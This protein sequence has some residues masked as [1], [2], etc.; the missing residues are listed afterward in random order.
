MNLR[1]IHYLV[2][3]ADLKSFSQAA[4]QCHISQPTLSAQVKKLEDLLGVQI[5]ERNNKR[6]MLT[7]TGERIVECARRI[8][9]EEDSIHAIANEA[10]DPFSGT[11][12]LG[13]FPTLASY[14]FPTVVSAIRADL[15]SLKLMLIEEKTAT[16]LDQIRAGTLDAAFIALP[17]QDPRLVET[18]LFDDEFF[19]AVPATH[20]LARATKVDQSILKQ[21]ELLLLDEG[22][23]LRDQA[24][25][26]CQL[27]G[28][29]E[30]T[31][32]RATSLETLRQ[33]VK[34]GTGVTLIPRIAISGTDTDIHYLPFREPAPSRRIGLVWRK[35]TT[36][37]KLIERVVT[38]LLP[39]LSGTEPLR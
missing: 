1:D 27:H 23:C 18:A 4:E 8:L 6:V 5:F 15:P 21:Y 14:V 19:L 17:V 29:H 28:G 20:E 2:A 39:I 13:A 24:L 22:H 35:T 11:F 12:K 31:G 3:V 9:R 30:Q 7:D 26:V 36:R 34:A 16:L 33:M 25:E 37:S 32:F 10:K 38:L